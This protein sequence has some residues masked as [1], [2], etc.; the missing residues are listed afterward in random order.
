MCKEELCKLHCSPVLLRSVIQLCVSAPRELCEL[1]G[2]VS[3]RIVRVRAFWPRLAGC[4]LQLQHCSSMHRRAARARA[5][6]QVAHGFRTWSTSTGRGTSD[7]AWPPSPTPRRPWE[8]GQA[9][10]YTEAERRRRPPQGGARR[11]RA[12]RKRPKAA[13]TSNR[14]TPNAM[15]AAAAAGAGID[16]VQRPGACTYLGIVENDEYAIAAFVLEP[17]RE[18]PAPRPPR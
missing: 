13:R 14:R 1:I 16:D 17:A 10:N 4:S 8:P 5:L 15:S 18:D 12:P 6:A 3:P 11:R 9:D 2:R 7:R